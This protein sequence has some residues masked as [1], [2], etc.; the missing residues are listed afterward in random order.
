MHSMATNQ[1]TLIAPIP[2]W[3]DGYLHIMSM[4]EHEPWKLEAPDWSDDKPNFQWFDCD[5]NVTMFETQYEYPEMLTMDTLYVMNVSNCAFD[6]YFHALNEISYW[7][8]LAFDVN[9]AYVEN[10]TGDM[11][12]SF[13]HHHI[14]QMC[15]YAFD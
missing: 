15:L 5:S 12:S 6:S 10:I 9:N 2:P 11:I 3:T 8:E 13:D 4:Y 7:T 14:G 1:L